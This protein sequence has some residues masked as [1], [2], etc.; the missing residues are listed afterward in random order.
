[1]GNIKIID[2]HHELVA[3]L[4]VL[5]KANCE[6]RPLDNTIFH[7]DSH[8]DVGHIKTPQPFCP[9]FDPEHSNLIDYLNIGNPFTLLFY[10]NL[11]NDFYWFSPSDHCHQLCQPFVFTVEHEWH[12]PIHFYKRRL[13][14]CL[15]TVFDS[16][17]LQL[18][19]YRKASIDSD[20]NLLFLLDSFDY[21]LIDTGLRDV[22][23]GKRGFI[24]DICYDY[25]YA[26]P[27][28][29]ASPMTISITEEYYTNFLTDPLHPVK[30][31]LGPI[32]RVSQNQTG[33]KLDIGGFESKQ[34]NSNCSRTSCITETIDSRMFY[35]EKFLRRLELPPQVIY[36]CR[37]SISNYTPKPYIGYIEKK[38][39]SLFQQL[40]FAKT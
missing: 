13:T 39:L 22:V 27:D 26:N 15:D 14:S 25:F 21:A 24:L 32:A 12:D 29:I 5:L 3:S 40:E 30:L 31:K 6:F 36:L 10:Y 2:E 37:S 7:F 4:G 8:S 17:K 20:D 34:I 33:F 11:I 19:T 9:E 18:P 35:F 38:L 23:C 28:H 16:R 1:M